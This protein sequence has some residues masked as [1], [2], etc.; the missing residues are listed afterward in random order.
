MLEDT[1]KSA[2]SVINK[3]IRHFE[4]VLTAEDTEERAEENR[5]CS[6]APSAKTSAFSA[7]NSFL[8]D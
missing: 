7:V 3:Q 6:F 2:A 4:L 8:T 5:S 1:D